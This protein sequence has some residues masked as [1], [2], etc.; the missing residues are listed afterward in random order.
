MLYNSHICHLI[1]IGMCGNFNDVASDDLA[2]ANGMANGDRNDISDSYHMSTLPPNP[3]LT[4]TPT[5]FD[6]I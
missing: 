5:P 6:I 1:F 4:T 2:L 3:T